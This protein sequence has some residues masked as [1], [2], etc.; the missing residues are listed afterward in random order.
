MQRA[1]SALLALLLV[2]ALAGCG[3]P[4]A[5]SNPAPL[6]EVSIVL[7]W[8]PNAVHS[9]LYVAQER[10]YFTDEGL[11]VQIKMPSENPTDGIKLVG[12]GRETFALYYHPDILTA[13]FNEAIPIVAVAA[14]VREPLSGIMAP[15][16]AGIA[17]PRDLAG[18]RVGYPSIPL[19]LHMVDTMVTAAGG[20]AGQVEMIDIG[21]DLIPAIATGRVDAVSGAYVN[22]ELPI[23]ENEGLAMV[24]FAP[25]DFGVPRYYE[26][27]LITGERTLQE[28]PELVA[29]FWRAAARGHRDVAADPAAGLQVLLD[30]QRAEFPLKEDV[31]AF[32]LGW[33]LPRM[34]EAGLP[35]G[36]QEA[37]R[38]QEVAAWLVERGILAEPPQVQ[39]AFVDIT[40]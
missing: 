39:E 33:L 15:A 37:E 19:N 8:Y 22:H 25:E 20:D 27:M 11:Q 28:D 1:L 6:R 23:F 35:F 32:S 2:A 34:E 31:E 7:D 24:R 30:N 18:R 12:A 3:R 4:A 21:W 16:G 13:R 9:F 36:A 10:G 5:E 29:A 26:L 14:V 38:W 17:S 40:R